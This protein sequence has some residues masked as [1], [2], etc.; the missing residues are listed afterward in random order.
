MVIK[1]NRAEMNRRQ[2]V[3]RSAIL[4]GGLSLSFALSGPNGAARAQVRGTEMN[5]WVLIAPDNTI[6]IRI[7]RIEIGQGVVT[8][9]AQF[10]AEEL[11]ADWSKVKTESASQAQHVKLNLVYGQRSVRASDMVQNDN[12]R[13][14]QVGAQT[15]AMLVKA[16]VVKL[17][18]P[19]MELTTENS[20]II[21]RAS[22]RRVTYGEIAA[23]AA[24][25]APPDAKTVAL[26]D[27]KDWKLLGKPLKRL[28]TPAKVNGSETY[29]V[30]VVLPG[31]K[32]AAIMISPV[33]GGSLK[34]YDA[35]AALARPGVRKVVEIKAIRP[36]AWPPELVP[37]AQAR[38]ARS[39]YAMWTDA[40]IAVVADT[41]WQAKTALEAMPKVWDEGQHGNLST[42][43][44]DEQ[45]KALLSGDK[46]VV[47]RKQGDAPNA[48]KSAAKVLEADYYTPLQHH[49]TMEPLN[50]TARVDE[51]KF[52]VWVG[53]QDPDGAIATAAV[54]AGLPVEKGEVHVLRAGGGF[55]R[56]IEQD[57]VS[58]AVQIAAAMKGTPIKMIWSRE[59]DMRHGRYMPSCY[60][61]MRG[62]L[63]A[64][65]NLIA[66]QQRVTGNSYNYAVSFQTHPPAPGT[67]PPPAIIP[68]SAGGGESLPHVIP[69]V[70][71]DTVAVPTALPL[72]PLRSVFTMPGAF[73]NQG[74]MDELAVAAGKDSVSFQRALLDPAKV[75][76]DAEKREALLE[77]IERWRR[78]LDL[79][80]EKSGWGRRL[81]AGHGRGLAIVE[82]GNT[83]SAAVAE[84]TLDGQGALKVDRIV[85]STDPGVVINPDGFNSQVEG[86]SI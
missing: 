11:D 6:T 27:P 16:A 73:F 24:K 61:R 38:A 80:A 50:C 86:G 2:F 71:V 78:V 15:R 39:P 81:G 13:L 40:G 21:H 65:G 10:I 64:A 67:V 75:P 12:L 1:V 42:D 77:R 14:R 56:R 34:S 26:K 30:D 17:G 60:A 35:Q 52:E 9:T 63:D 72:G 7:G 46:S 59:E 69:N 49:A 57:F 66:W 5:A 32:H 20:T 47:A 18:V 8:A 36:I 19:E 83:T 55:G 53:T 23:D 70:L 79:V 45:L 48:L 37:A 84:V 3:V 22:N 51:D 25:I 31:M 54:V 41:W 82:Q 33:F 62:G 76:A 29:G 28:D 43:A 74:F 68:G 85:V 4:G 44:Y 58:Q